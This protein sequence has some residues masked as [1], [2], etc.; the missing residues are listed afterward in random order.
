MYLCQKQVQVMNM[1]YHIDKDCLEATVTCPNKCKT[2]NKL[3]RR[4]IQS[5]LDHDRE[6]QVISCPY[7]CGEKHMRSIMKDHASSSSLELSQMHLRTLETHYRKW[8]HEMDCDLAT[9]DFQIKFLREALPDEEGQGERASSASTSSTD[10]PSSAAPSRT[11]RIL[12]GEQ[13]ELVVGVHL[14]VD[15]KNDWCLGCIIERRANEGADDSVLYIIH[16]SQ[17]ILMNGCMFQAIGYDS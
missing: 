3:T 14:A 11:L 12:T 17:I 7:F 15:N 5:H 9:R 4:N 16:F 10:R 13:K 2:T 6:L 8:K 1:S